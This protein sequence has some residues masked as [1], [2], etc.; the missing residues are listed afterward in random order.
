MSSQL[1]TE[2]KADGSDTNGKAISESSNTDPSVLKNAA[3]GG[4]IG[5]IGGAVVGGFAGGPLGAVIGAVVGGSAS[6]A[7]VDMIELHSPASSIGDNRSA[8]TSD[9]E[10]LTEGELPPALAFYAAPGAFG[11]SLPGMVAPPITAAAFGED[12]PSSTSTEDESNLEPLFKPGSD[13]Q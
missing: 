2:P 12:D 7:A 4:I 10:Q 5:A 1:T 8:P 6:A 13:N 9:R 11:T 3:E